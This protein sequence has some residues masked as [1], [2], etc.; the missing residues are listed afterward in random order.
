MVCRQL[1][2]TDVSNTF[3][4]DTSTF[5]GSRPDYDLDEVVCNG[6]ETR[7]SD[8]SHTGWGVNNC[9]TTY[10]EDVELRCFTLGKQGKTSQSN[11]SLY[12]YTCLMAPLTRVGSYREVYIIS[13]NIGEAGRPIR[14]FMRNNVVNPRMVLKLY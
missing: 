6:N 4:H 8:C 5:G 14:F 13:R 3:D 11:A 1:G 10:Y 2:F 9:F 12:F 7:L